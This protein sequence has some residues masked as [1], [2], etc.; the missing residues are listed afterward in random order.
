MKKN[1]LIIFIILI[2]FFAMSCTAE[3]N[4][5]VGGIIISISNAIS[6]GIAPNISLDVDHYIVS[7]NGPNDQTFTVTLDSSEPAYSN[8]ELLAGNWTISV[9]AYNSNDILIGTGEES[10]KITAGQSKEVSLTVYECSGQGTINVSLTVP[11]N[12]EYIINIQHLNNGL[13]YDSANKTLTPDNGKIETSFL[14]NNG[15]HLIRVICNNSNVRVPAPVS[16]RLVKD[17]TIN[18][19][20]SASFL[21]GEVSVKIDDKIIETPVFQISVD[22][23]T[24][25]KNENVIATI[26]SPD[27]A[28]ENWEFQWYINGKNV[29]PSEEGI[30]TFSEIG[31]YEISCLAINQ[32]TRFVISSKATVM[33]TE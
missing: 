26:N 14:I 27:I 18:V 17:D 15:F 32:N 4:S 16:L 3:N 12:D 10:V 13:N 30:F 20:L 31:T 29:I 19:S 22:K 23:N 1:N 6:R 8:D 5:S 11:T 33:V 21:D 2:L 25:S 9:N 28:V 7:G 24:V